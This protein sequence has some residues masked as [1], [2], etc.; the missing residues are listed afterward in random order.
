MDERGRRDDISGRKQAEGEAAPQ[1][2]QRPVTPP[3]AAARPRLDPPVERGRTQGT[4]QGQGTQA[5]REGAGRVN[6]APPAGLDETKVTRM[7]PVVEPSRFERGGQ[8]G[9]PVLPPASPAR[10]G[11]AAG[12][13]LEGT[14]QRPAVQP[15][16]GQTYQ[17]NQPVR[18]QVRKPGGWQYERDEQGAGRNGSPYAAYE[19]RVQ[20]YDGGY[21]PPSGPVTRRPEQPAP[22]QGRGYLAVNVEGTRRRRRAGSWVLWVL[23][24]AVAIAAVGVMAFSLAWQGQYAGKVYAGVSALDIGLGG[25]TPDEAKKLLRDK[26]QGFAAQP[27][28]LTWRGKEWRPSAEQL[29]VKLDVDAT[30]N[31]AFTVGRR[32]DALS[33]VA[34]QWDAAQ[35]GYAVP[36]TVQISEPVMQDYLAGLAQTEIDQKLFDGD[37]RLNGTEV[38]A[39]PG[40]EGRTLRVYDAIKV[41]RDGVAKAVSGSG[42]KIEQGKIDLPVEV[43]Q[44]SVSAEEV[45]SIEGLLAVRVSGPITATAPGGKV[46]SLDRDALVRFTTIERNPDR[47]ASRH[48]ELGWNDKELKVLGAKWA[49]DASRP[50]QNARFGWNNGSV[51]VLNESVDGF[52]TD[53]NA[54]VSSIKEAAGTSDKRQYQLPGKVLTPTVSS[55][56]IGALGIKE[57]MGTGTS[58]FAGSSQERATNIRVAAGLINGAVVPPG[59]TFSFLQTVGGIDEAH[60][61]VEGYVIAAERTQKGVGGG[62]CQVSTTVFRAAFWS[63]VK[64][65]ERNQHS[66]RVSWYEANGEPVGFDAAVFDPGVDLTFI[67]DSPGYML[68]EAKTGPDSLTV[69]FYGTKPKGQVKL[70]GPAISNRLPPPPDVYQVDTRLPAGTKKQVETAHG[71]LDTVITRRIVTPGQPD[72]VDKFYSSYKAWPNWFIVASPSQVPGG[73]APAPNPTPNP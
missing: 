25:K 10:L 66:Y 56:D 63:G 43:V 20:P 22:G 3:P 38:V 50:P 60:G 15:G 48:I 68:L 58:T 13:P 35:T 23:V 6:P 57:L 53:A 34:Q 18:P 70:E 7:L 12:Q 26:V 37:V 54:V 71:G 21:A 59:G 14:A 31:D 33:N 19:D 55:K 9:E 62:V 27:F 72:K 5:P 51:A 65:T 17:P 2:P 29:G 1:W 52:Q 69:N 8:G 11:G 64:I 49:S 24:G 4:P 36:L 67:N 45:Q 73:V 28:I 47:S 44:P 30:V 46:M 39:L 61:F 42:D 40:K 41:V 16:G 32:G